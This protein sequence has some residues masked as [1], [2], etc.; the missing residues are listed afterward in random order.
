VP[1][2]GEVAAFI[3]RKRHGGR[4]P[5]DPTRR[6]SVAESGGC[7]P[8]VELVRRRTAIVSLSNVRYEI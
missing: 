8:G 3:I 2:T 1:V 7:P 5:V 4:R 6:S